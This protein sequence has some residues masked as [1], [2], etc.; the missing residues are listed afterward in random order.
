MFFIFE[1]HKGRNALGLSEVVIVHKHCSHSF[2]LFFVDRK[3][4]KPNI[5][6]LDSCGLKI[7]IKGSIVWRSLTVDC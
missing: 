3:A 4:L 7:V 2:L 5:A 1:M 6:S